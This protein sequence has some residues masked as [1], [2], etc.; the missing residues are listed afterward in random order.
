MNDF[1]PPVPDPAQVAVIPSD[2]AE[3]S[4]KTARMALVA[5]LVLGDLLALFI[6]FS[7]AEAVRGDIWLK[8]GDVSLL[9]IV[10]P[11]FLVLATN[12]GAYSLPAQSRYAE[13]ARN[14][15]GALGQT[16]LALFGI[17]FAVQQG[18]DIS[19]VGMGVVFLVSLAA[20]LFFRLLNA[21]WVRRALGGVLVDELVI[22]DGVANPG[23]EARFMIDA[24]KN[25]LEPDLNNPAML[26][27]FSRICDCYD[28]VLVA[29][30]AERQGV[31]ATL[32][33][34]V[35]AEAELIVGQQQNFKVI[36]LSSIG[37]LRT[38][39]VSRGS[40]TLIDR[41][42]KRL[43][44]LAIAV[45]ALLFLGPLMIAVAIA[46]KLDSR[47]PV[48]FRQPR[49][50]R[51]N[52]IFEIL[53]FRSMRQELGDRDGTRST[54]RDDDR[55]SRVG[56]F[57]RRTS[58]DEL[59]QLLNVIK[60]DMSIVGP[61]PH[62][63][64][65]TAENRLF[66]EISHRYWERHLLKP[67]ITGLAQVRGFRGATEKTSDFTDRLTSDLEYLSGWRLWRDVAILAATLKVLVH[68]N[69]Y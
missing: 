14:V 62:A 53:K 33:R 35:D 11:L 28:R 66:W 1:N 6:G 38:L 56:R 21:F 4:R 15:I 61:R 42:K 32:L 16:L 47:G 55:I 25:G 13:S 59:P 8:L 44:D 36:G 26:E 64:G 69:A 31:W 20:M 50:G 29:C 30:P 34:T 39:V 18:E 63:L 23:A 46:I 57:I 48:L 52:V 54:G 43:F 10:L 41:I 51:N 9:Y 49:V 67:G 65:S 5:R 68:P 60:G 19:R 45:P 24:R 12:A 22:L 7:L 3:H 2:A 27:R 40:L 17:L 37:D 58:I